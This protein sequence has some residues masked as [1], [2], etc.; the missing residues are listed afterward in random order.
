MKPANPVPPTAMPARVT[1]ATVPELVIPPL[2]VEIVTELAPRS[3]TADDDACRLREDRTG[4]ADAA[5]EG[6]N[7]DRRAGANSVSN[8]ADKDLLALFAVIAPLL[9]MPP[10]KAD[11]LTDAPDATAAPP[12]RIPLPALAAIVPLLLMP[13]LKVEI[14]MDVPV[15]VATPPTAMA[16]PPALIVPVLVIPPETA[17][18]LVTRISLLF[19]VGSIVICPALM[20]APPMVLLLMVM[21][22]LSEQCCRQQ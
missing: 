3:E 4:V 10:V 18:L 9:V 12:T 13:P 1:A 22:V 14:V 6:R 20:I 15:W 2:K 16:L 17:A 11:T 5:A 21:P 8:A 7:R 19:D